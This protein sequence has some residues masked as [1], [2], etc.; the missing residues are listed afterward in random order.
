MN[1]GWHRDRKATWMVHWWVLLHSAQNMLTDPLASIHALRKA[2]FVF[3][4]NN[5]HSQKA[6]P[7]RAEPLHCQGSLC[8]ATLEARFR[9]LVCCC[10][11]SLVVVKDRNWESQDKNGTSWISQVVIR[12][13]NRRWDE[14]GETKFLGGEGGF[15]LYYLFPEIYNLRLLFKLYYFVGT[16]LVSRVLNWLPKFIAQTKK[17]RGVSQ[18]GLAIFIYE[19]R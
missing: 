10:L 18:C 12:Y 3:Y 2:C 8:L 11:S 4:V 6:E 1:L 13:K 19:G 7:L 14:S 5:F 9:C 16:S 17:T 15:K